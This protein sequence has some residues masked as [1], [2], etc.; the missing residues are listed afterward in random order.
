MIVFENAIYVGL[1]VKMKIYNKY[2]RLIEY[3]IYPLALLLLPLMNYNQGVDV[4]DS[5]YSLGNYLFAD[6]LQG[7]WVI[8][9]YLSNVIGS[10]IM[11]LPGA[12]TLRVANIYT[13]LI[14][15]CIG[16]LVYFALRND[17]DSRYVFLGEFAALAFCWIPT[18]ILYNYLSYCLM[19]A[20]ALL[21]YKAIIKDNKKMFFVAGLVLGANVFVRIPNI[22]QM[23][24]IVALWT[25]CFVTGRKWIKDTLI[26]VGGYAVGVA[27][28][29][30][31][32]IA[33]YGLSE[34]L[35]MINGL[36][37][38]TTT[39]NT[40]SPLSMITGSIK[41]YC[42]SFRW[43]ALVLLVLA[44]GI[45]MFRIMPKRFIW[46][47]TLVYIAVIALMI[48]FFWGRG[49]FSFRYYEDYTSMYEWGVMALFISI[50]ADI[51]IIVKAIVSRKVL[52]SNRVASNV[53][54]TA[55]SA[56]SDGGK[57]AGSD[58]GISVS[59]DY[60]VLAKLVM[61]V[62]SLIVILIAPLGS[63]NNLYQ[64]INN[65]FLVMPFTV[66]MIFEWI[67]KYAKR[68]D[69]T[70]VPVSVMLYALLVCI[71]VQSFGFSQNFVF[72]DG[73]RGEK[74]DT[75]ISGINSLEGMYTNGANA[76]ALSGVCH[77][78]EDT[79]QQTEIDSLILFG[80]CPGLTYILNKPS[81]LFSSWIDLDSNPASQIEEELEIIK[82]SD[83]NI[84][85]IVRNIEGSAVAYEQKKKL[86][87]DFIADGGYL[88]VYSNDLY[89]VYNR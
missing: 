48:R 38:I 45:L 75:C 47:K 79:N 69:A 55:I 49:M 59:L 26:C 4:S 89:N 67:K 37:A 78:I 11:K 27:I 88:L 41:A 74:R 57:G 6:R 84:P 58:S 76:E 29:A 60:G 64:N 16:L 2:K 13:G 18:G 82:V 1:K 86:I 24:F 61:A 42:M 22:T 70:S 9:T 30:L 53:S 85:V 54:D 3:V 15:S 28:P 44:C 46:L 80:D 72:R 10:F 83:K 50:V 35:S 19:A 68:K 52:F 62:I 66:Y 14:L 7:M 56:D 43:F 12:T 51:S 17:F 8:S 87:D 71:L 73:M 40:Y 65:L 81:A 32:I 34:I 63:N 25:A 20:G 21:L 39:D 5:T 33:K 23:A 31:Y 77:F 36:S